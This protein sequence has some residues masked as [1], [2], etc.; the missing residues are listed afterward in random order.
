MA[1]ELN[2]IY[3]KLR[4]LKENLFKLSLERRTPERL[5][6]KLNEATIIYNDYSV[7]LVSIRKQ[8]DNKTISGESLSLVKSH[9]DKIVEL[10]AQIQEFCSKLHLPVTRSSCEQFGET[11]NL[12]SKMEFNLKI[13]LSLLPVMNNEELTTRQL[14]D[15]IEYYSSTLKTE[16]CKLSLINFV[17]KSRLSQ[18]AKLSLKSDY[19]SI[20]ALLTDMRMILLPKKSAIA[21]QNKLQTSRQDQ[22]SINDYGKELT[23]LFMDLSIAQAE[24]K[25]ENLKI[26]QPLNEKQAIKRFADG[27]R[28]RRLS[29]IIAAQKFES[30]KDAV[31]AAID[32]ETI[33]F[34]SQSFDVLTFR[35]RS[36]YFQGHHH[37]EANHQPRR[38]S[39]NNNFS[40]FT[41]HRGASFYR[42]RG[43][44]RSS[45][46]YTRGQPRQYRG[47]YYNSYLR[48]N[49]TR[50][51]QK[52]SQRSDAHIHVLK[53]DEPSTSNSTEEQSKFFRE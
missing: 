4:K 46:N 40:R 39:A 29:T 5:K 45:Q 28:N 6:E 15:G 23:E 38:N 8:I 18:Q 47:T 51:H 19:P 24:G 20:D 17:L 16:Q 3:E 9:C 32:E 21:L 1:L 2:D 14:I 52:N 50:G 37:R 12:E 11:S 35:K 48:Y 30:L 27:L 26:L 43:R 13:A 22:R 33:T 44:G 10:N 42:G 36:N 7:L 34:P 31:Q 25:T 49:N 53:N 41:G